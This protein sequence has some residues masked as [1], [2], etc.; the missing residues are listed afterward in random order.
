MDNLESR[1]K[2]LSLRRPS[3]ALDAR[4]AAQKPVLRPRRPSQSWWRR[5]ISIPL[6][7]V[8]LFLALLGGSLLLHR[9]HENVPRGTPSATSA[10]A[11]A[12]PLSETAPAAPPRED[13]TGPSFDSRPQRVEVAYYVPGEG[14][15]GRRTVIGIQEVIE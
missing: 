9:P 1:L 8:V 15:V 3:D 11:K 7:V 4:V 2:S 12:M 14:V 13:Q 5:R 10:G 6:P